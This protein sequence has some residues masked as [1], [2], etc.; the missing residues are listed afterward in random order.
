MDEKLTMSSMDIQEK[1]LST[2]L[3]IQSD[4]K[5]LNERMGKVESVQEKVY[6]KL[7]GFM[8]LVNRHE[9]EIAAA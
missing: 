9:A 3:D 8:L 2:V 1:N 4:I 7:D 6:D 5:N